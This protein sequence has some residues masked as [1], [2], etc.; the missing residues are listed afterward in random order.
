MGG[1]IFKVYGENVSIDDMEVFTSAAPW[2]SQ[3]D[4]LY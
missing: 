4:L 1:Y 3:N 2:M